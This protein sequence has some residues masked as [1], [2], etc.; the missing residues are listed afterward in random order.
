MPSNQAPDDRPPPSA[1]VPRA[2]AAAPL[3]ISAGAAGAAGLQPQR[4]AQQQPRVRAEERR[5]ESDVPALA[6]LGWVL[7]IDDDDQVRRILRTMLELGGYEVLD[8]ANLEFA[9]ASYAQHD[10]RVLIYDLIQP[11]QELTMGLQQ[12]R[13]G[14]LGAQI[15]AISGGGRCGTKPLLQVAL[16]LGAAATLVKPISKASLLSTVASLW[17]A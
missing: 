7:V 6:P 14:F 15:L 3:K 17:A 10:V 12:A 8:A 13:S 1:L 5:A 9:L 11:D 2:Q 16:E 4:S